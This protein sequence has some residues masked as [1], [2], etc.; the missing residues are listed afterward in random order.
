[1]RI[2]H[3]PRTLAI[4]LV[5]WRH[6]DPIILVFI[7]SNCITMAWESP[8]DPVGTSK[9]HFVDAREQVY[10]GVF[11]CEWVSHRRSKKETMS[12][13]PLRRSNF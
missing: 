5:E 7:V 2:D 13:A 3:Q 11:T 8:L 6:F 1:M 10:L 4:R 9:A 12:H